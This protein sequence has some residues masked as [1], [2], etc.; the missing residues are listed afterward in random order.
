MFSVVVLYDNAADIE[1]SSIC[2]PVRSNRLWNFLEGYNNRKIICDGFTQGFRI[3][4]SRPFIR[5]HN[6]KPQNHINRQELIKKLNTELENGRILGPYLT[7]P[8]TN[9]IISPLYIIPKS[10]PGKFRLIHDLSSPKSNSVNEHIREEDKSVHYCSLLDVAKF[11]V[12]HG[13]NKWW[14]S[15]IDLKDA[16]RCVPI[17]KD[18]WRYLGMRFQDKYMCDICLPME[19]GTSCRIF[20]EISNSL[21]WIFLNRHPNAMIFNYLDDFL[22]LATSESKC[23]TA[24]D[25]FLFVLDDIGFPVSQEK[26][27]EP[28][29]SV[30]FLGLGINSSELSF[31][32][33]DSKRTKTADMIT[34]FLNKKRHRVH[35]IQKLVGVLTFLCQSLLP[36][37]SLLGSLH[38]QLRGILSQDSWVMRRISHGVSE[39]L[40]VWRQFLTSATAEKKFRFL[41]PD[42]EPSHTISTD[43]SGSIG[44]GAVMEGRWFS[45]TWDDEWWS[46]QNI[47]LL[48]LY[49]I[50]AALHSWIQELSNSC[51]QIMTDNMALVTMLNTMY[52]KDKKLNT[53]LKYCAM[54]VMQN[55]VVVRAYHIRSEDNTIPDRLSRNL[56]CSH[57]LDESQQFLIPHPYSLQSTKDLLK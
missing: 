52:S 8:L 9:L 42:D 12:E 11:L 37:K 43:A 14:M 48:E 57:L 20:T 18:D 32:I 4:I 7:A 6:H 54:L 47:A 27:V 45:G 40:K 31:F 38:Q 35:T 2:T 56:D 33:P 25:D 49:P 34:S 36:G 5:P 51:V 50:Y 28:C 17:H 22:I 16:Y 53:L 26:T 15:K 19:L 23:K 55:N 44:Y 46:D 24:L 1:T 30:E 3:G 41:F 13:D 21:A 39:D 29:Q 10:T